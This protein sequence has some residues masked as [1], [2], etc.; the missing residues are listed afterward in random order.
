MNTRRE[1]FESLYYSA[2]ILFIVTTLISL[3]WDNAFFAGVR[4]G[5]IICLLIFSA[6]FKKRLHLYIWLLIAMIYAADFLLKF[7]FL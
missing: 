5:L 4:G 2:A 1:P 6:T 3:F 7:D